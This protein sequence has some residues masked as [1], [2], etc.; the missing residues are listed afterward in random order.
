[1]A[2]E[3]ESWIGDQNRPILTSFAVDMDSGQI[4]LTFNETVNA[5][6][7]DVTCV[8]L[9]E[10]RTT[11]RA[12]CSTT[13]GRMGPKGRGRRVALCRRVTVPR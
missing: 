2:L 9:H 8:S 13:C 3:P 11:G 4:D 6:E 12:G 7:L 5:N 10:T 1:M